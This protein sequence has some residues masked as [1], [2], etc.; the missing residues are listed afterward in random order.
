MGQRKPSASRGSW[1]GVDGVVR[2]LRAAD[3]LVQPGYFFDF[4]KPGH[5]VASL[6]PAPA[7]FAEAATRLA[8][9]I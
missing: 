9:N 2:P 7:L 8:A 5:L 4:E 6:L 3:V 1:T